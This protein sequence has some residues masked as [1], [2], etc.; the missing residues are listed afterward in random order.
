M[1]GGGESLP[2]QR[3]RSNRD[4]GR[5]GIRMRRI[6][7]RRHL[8]LYSPGDDPSGRQLIRFAPTRPP[9]AA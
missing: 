2:C 9:G 6:P 7:R 5:R 8:K 3:R 4:L 1:V